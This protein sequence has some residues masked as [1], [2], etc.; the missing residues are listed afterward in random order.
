[1][2]SRWSMVRS[3]TLTVIGDQSADLLKDIA[4][5]LEQFRLVVGGAFRGISSP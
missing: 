4:S 2:T 3:E 5:R 1:M